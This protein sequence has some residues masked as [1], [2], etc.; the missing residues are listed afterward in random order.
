MMLDPLLLGAA[1]LSLRKAR[2]RGIRST[3]RD[4]L[5]SIS[6]GKLA[7]ACTYLE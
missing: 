6:A 3:V 1:L 7:W 5:V 4:G 2:L